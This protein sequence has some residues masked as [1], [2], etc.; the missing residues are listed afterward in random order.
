[1][2][3]RELHEGDLEIREAAMVAL[4]ALGPDAL[5]A[6]RGVHSRIDDQEVFARLQ[7]VI[8]R[9]EEQDGLVRLVG[10]PRLVDLSVRRAPIHEVLKEL[11]R[12]SAVRVE[13]EDLPS[14]LRADVD[15][16][17][18]PVWDAVDDLCRRHGNL[19]PRWSGDRVTIQP[20]LFRE[21]TGVEWRVGPV[22]MGRFWIESVLENSEPDK[23]PELRLLAFLLTAP[24][25]RFCQ[26]YLFVDQIQQGERFLVEDE[27]GGRFLELPECNYA[28]AEGSILI[29]VLARIRCAPQ[30]APAELRNVRGR[31]Y[32]Y[33]SRDISPLVSLA[34]LAD[35]CRTTDP[36][37]HV[38]LGVNKVTRTPTEIRVNS[39]AIFPMMSSRD[40]IGG[41]QGVRLLSKSGRAY[42]PSEHSEQGGG[43]DM[44]AEYWFIDSTF[45]VPSEVEIAAFQVLQPERETCQSFPIDF[46]FPRLP[47]SVR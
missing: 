24:G 44:G 1:T 38:S 9:L 16:Y 46:D 10:R 47:L 40:R 25:R 18:V 2:R 5:P 41:R 26:A 23:P 4:A 21:T 34:T 29:P 36:T 33:I 30:P 27:S 20:G 11:T 22:R 15:V 14:D 17:G 12:Q 37:S 6:I 13:G 39:H 45:S 28:Y 42:Y 31:V 35:G 8:E 32:F 43:A 19:V 7:S 3:V